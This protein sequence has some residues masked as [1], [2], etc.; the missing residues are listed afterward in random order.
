MIIRANVFI[1]PIL[2]P[3]SSGDCSKLNKAQPLV[4]MPGMGISLNNGIELQNT[5]AKIL[6][7]LQ[8]V[9]NQLFTDMLGANLAGVTPLL[10]EPILLEDGWS[11][12]VRRR[13]EAPLLR[14]YRGE[15]R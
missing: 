1:A 5:E 3:K 6:C 9:Q 13:L 10:V 15:G 7:D 11:F 12:K 2:H 8:A 4:Q 14:R